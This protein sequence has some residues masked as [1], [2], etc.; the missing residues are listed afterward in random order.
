MCDYCGCRNQ[1]AINELSQEHDRLLD[2]AYYLDRLA[3]RG[4]H[5]EVLEVLDDEFASLLG[6]HTDKEEAGLFTQL[7]S[8][9]ETD[10]RL[11]T[12]IGEHRQIEASLAELR[13][14]GEGWRQALDRLVDDLD[15]HIL[16]EEVDLFPYAMYEL[17]ASHWDQVA[18][19]HA[20]APGR[21]D[22]P[23]PAG[24]IAPGPPSRRIEGSK[25]VEP[26]PATR[27]GTVHPGDTR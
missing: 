8:C 6:H 9:D 20:A 27:P 25:D 3:R 4:S 26:T 14:G 18:Q 19:V 23:P 24:A 12:L 5:A 7:R 11:D 16:D 1:P 13:A 15:E 22:R 2:L 10:D 17:R 21:A